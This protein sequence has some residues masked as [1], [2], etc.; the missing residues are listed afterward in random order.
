MPRRSPEILATMPESSSLLNCTGT[1][2]LYDIKFV[3]NL[4]LRTCTKWMETKQ[5]EQQHSTYKQNHSYSSLQIFKLHLAKAWKLFFSSHCH[6]SQ[7]TSGTQSHRS[8]SEAPQARELKD[9]GVQVGDT[10][11]MMMATMKSVKAMLNQ[12]RDNWA[13]WSHTSD[14]DQ[15]CGSLSHPCWITWE[16]TGQLGHTRDDDV[17]LEVCQTPCWSTR[18][19]TVTTSLELHLSPLRKAE[20]STVRSSPR[21]QQLEYLHSGTLQR[22][23]RLS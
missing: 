3:R 12:M 15:H 9:S 11:V 8:L 23:W 5:W 4:I 19:I 2:R 1:A 20:N 13:A 14:D 17:H 16:I 21:K 22:A 7:W 18:E 6:L 10:Q